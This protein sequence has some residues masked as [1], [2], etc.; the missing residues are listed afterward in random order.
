MCWRCCVFPLQKIVHNIAEQVIELPYLARRSLDIL[1]CGVLQF[2][3]TMKLDQAVFLFIYSFVISIFSTSPKKTS[4]LQQQLI[5]NAHYGKED[6]SAV[7]LK[8]C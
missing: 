1:L 4:K 6:K 7:E 2:N 3:P 5:N 8:K